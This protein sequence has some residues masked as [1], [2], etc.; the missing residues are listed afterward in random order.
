MC[1]VIN[2]ILW[3]SPHQENLIFFEIWNSFILR[4]LRVLRGVLKM[5]VKISLEKGE[6]RKYFRKWEDA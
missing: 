3:L 4:V 1:S 5:W 2:N 6:I